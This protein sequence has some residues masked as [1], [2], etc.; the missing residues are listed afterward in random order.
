MI[1]RLELLCWLRT[2][3]CGDGSNLCALLLDR[4][5]KFAGGAAAGND[6]DLFQPLLDRGGVCHGANI[7]GNAITKFA[8]YVVPSKKPGDAI[9]GELRITRLSSR[10]NMWCRGG[11]RLVHDR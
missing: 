5:C 6:P 8:R 9:E 2:N 7:G 3:G 1:L 10:G 4:S 11:A